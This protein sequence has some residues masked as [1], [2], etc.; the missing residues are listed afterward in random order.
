MKIKF[1]L[2]VVALLN[3]ISV[4]A[5]PTVNI[6]PFATGFNQGVCDI[7]NAGDSRLFVVQQLGYISVVDSAGNV[8][9]NYFLNIHN[10]VTPSVFSPGSEQGLLGLA[11]SPN[12]ATDGFFYV[13]Y[14]NKTGQGNSVIARYHVSSNPDSADAAS[15]Q[16]LLTIPQPYSNHNGGC[17]KFG[18]DGYLYCGFGDGGASGDPENRAQNTDSLLGK[19]LRI[20]VSGGAG[21]TIPPTNPF[22]VSGGAPEIWAYG[23]RNPWRFSFDRLTHDLWIGDVG[24]NTYE[25]IDFQSASSSGGENYGWRCYEGNT[26]FNTIG[27]LPVGSYVPPVHVYS[28]TAANGCSVTGGFVYRGSDY[29]DLSG[30]YF[31]SDYCAGKIYA[32]SSTFTPSIAGTFAGQN[33][34]TFGENAD[35]EIYVASQSNGTVYKMVSTLVSVNEVAFESGNISL[36]PNPNNGEFTCELNLKKDTK[37]TITIT[38]ITGRLLSET[39]ITLAAGKTLVPLNVSNSSKGVYLIKIQTESGTINKKFEILND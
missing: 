1:T 36:Y 21:Y 6:V 30:Y 25:E 2:L 5:Q 4:I 14:T 18:N 34:V 20:D 12:Y 9:P 7:A 29:P 33:F 35:G 32:L 27:C 10:K 39:Q 26:P 19:I 38:D 8:S 24:Q 13:N 37:A 31:Y 28:H 3:S 15:E 17:L 22:A 16:I 23:V 11:F